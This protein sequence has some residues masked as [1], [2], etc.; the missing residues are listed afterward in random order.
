MQIEHTLTI[1]G[2]LT[3]FLSMAILSPSRTVVVMDAPLDQGSPTS[4]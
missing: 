3:N 1:G 2:E 4:V